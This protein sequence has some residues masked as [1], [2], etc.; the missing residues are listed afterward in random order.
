M[1]LMKALEFQ[2]NIIDHTHI[3]RSLLYKYVND[4]D[5]IEDIY[6]TLCNN[7]IVYY[8]SDAYFTIHPIVYAVC[9]YVYHMNVHI[10]DILDASSHTYTIIL[11]SY[12]TIKDM[13]DS[14]SNST[15]KRVCKTSIDR[16]R[17][18]HKRLSDINN[19][20]TFKQYAY[21]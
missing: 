6:T 4:V 20:S 17:S 21:V 1:K 11:S 15:Y 2:L 8:R 18:F 5:R 19:G 12:D 14:S 7:D 16:Y 10:H 13:M 9:H 3:Y